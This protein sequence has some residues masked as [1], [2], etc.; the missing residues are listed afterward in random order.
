MDEL[1]AVL[2]APRPVLR[3]RGLAGVDGDCARSGVATPAAAYAVAISPTVAV[4]A[5][6]QWLAGRHCPCV[7]VA[8]L[9][10]LAFAADRS[11]SGRPA[12]AQRATTDA[13]LARAVT[14]PW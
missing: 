11:A 10:V 8:A 6:D 4:C 9:D 12:L 14:C 13:R 2:A 5:G 7:C 1:D 3:S